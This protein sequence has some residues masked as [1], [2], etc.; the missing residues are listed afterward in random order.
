MLCF[1]AVGYERIFDSLKSVLLELQQDG[2]HPGSYTPKTFMKAA[3]N[4]LLL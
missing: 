3:R 4:F 1:T 2:R